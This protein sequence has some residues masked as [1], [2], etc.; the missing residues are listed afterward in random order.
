MSHTFE[1]VW[2]IIKECKGKTFKM[3]SGRSLSFKIEKDDFI[4]IVDGVEKN[5]RQN[6]P[7]KSDAQWYY[8][9]KEEG[10]GNWNNYSINGKSYIKPVMDSRP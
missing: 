6:R 10:R 4:P 1:D 8:N 3:A 9:N 2:K 7:G 5:F